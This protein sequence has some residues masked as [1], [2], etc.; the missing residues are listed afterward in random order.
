MSNNVGITASTNLRLFFLNHG[1]FSSV[2]LA[3][4]RLALLH[5]KTF[6]EN[7]LGSLDRNGKM[8]TADTH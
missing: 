3:W 1:H 6:E 7:K 2:L 8:K 5:L 4:R